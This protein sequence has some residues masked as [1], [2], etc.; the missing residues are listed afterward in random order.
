MNLNDLLK[1]EERST[2]EFKELVN[3]SV[4][5][6][7]SAFSNTNGGLL[8]LGIS[9][10]K[11]VPG[12]DC[13]NRSIEGM[14]SRIINKLGIHP[15]IDVIEVNG[16]HVL[17]VEVKKSTLPISYEGRYYKRVGNTTR[18]MQGEELRTFFTKGNNWDGLTGDYSLE[19]ITGEA[20]IVS[21]SLMPLS[22]MVSASGHS[23]FLPENDLRE[24]SGSRD[25]KKMMVR[26]YMWKEEYNGLL[27]D[28]I[29]R[30]C[31]HLRLS[32]VNIFKIHCR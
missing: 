22:E 24:Y 20:D 4:F 31:V 1:I 23:L 5:K 11:E 9:D 17:K 16:K 29:E 27:G 7:L 10:K 8:Y 19:E 3:D 6:S 32:A 28:L 26:E 12:F 18:E 14:T 15:Q 25:N 21:I 13:S 2:M 30:I